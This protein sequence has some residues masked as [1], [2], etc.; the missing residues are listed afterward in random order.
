MLGRDGEVNSVSGRSL[1]RIN[2]QIVCERLGGGGHQTMAG[3]QIPDLELD[4]AEALV[5]AAIEQYTQE[6]RETV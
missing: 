3:A 5:R 4:E 6:V 2:V 1:G